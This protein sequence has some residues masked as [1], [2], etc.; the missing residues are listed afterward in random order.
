MTRDEA[1]GRIADANKIA[2]MTSWISAMDSRVVKDFG[3]RA[4]LLGGALALFMPATDSALFNRVIGLGVT[5][6]A[7]HALVRRIVQEYRRLG[8]SFMI[9]LAPYARPAELP[10]WLAEEGLEHGSDWLILYRDSTPAAA[11][12]RPSPVTVT[13]ATSGH[14]ELFAETLCT[15]Y[16]MPIEWAPLYQGFV[17]HEPWRHYLAFNGNQA[18]GTSSLLMNGSMVYLGNSTTLPGHRKRGVQTTLNGERLRQG[19]AAQCTAFTVDTW[20]PTAQEPNQS[21]RN[22]I[23]DGFDITYI[24]R[25]HVWRP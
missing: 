5:R 9:H 18:V 10:S 23:S 11:R 1:R 21:L 24:R 13:R 2:A 6:Q 4:E 16:G 17:G 8:T 22:H 20:R 15:G 14:A 3:V 25:N 19:L 12:N 7:S